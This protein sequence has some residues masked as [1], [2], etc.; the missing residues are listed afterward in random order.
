MAIPK[1]KKEVKITLDKDVLVQLELI[2]RDL[3][4]TKSAAISFL[5]KT[6]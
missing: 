2:A 4:V 5:I 3:G 6:F 1:A